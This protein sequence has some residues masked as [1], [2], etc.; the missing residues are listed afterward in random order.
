M[1]YKTFPVSA[2][3]PTYNGVGLL[4]K[5]LPA[6]I[7]CL[8]G[9]SEIIIVDDASTDSSIEW[10]SQKYGL[11]AVK[12]LAA[13]FD[14]WQGKVGELMLKVVKNHRNLRFSAN[15]NRGVELATHDWIFLLNSDV[16]PFSD[17]M[18]QVVTYFDDPTL[19]A[20]GCLEIE[21]DTKVFGGKNK[22]WFERGLFV[23]SRADTYTTG[24]TAWVSGGSGFFNRSK[25]VELKGFDEAYYPAYWEDVDLSYR[26]RKKG[27]K[28]W[29]EA[30]A[31]VHHNHE[32]TN[33]SVFGQRKMEI[34]S[35]TNAQRFV[36]KNGTPWQ[37]LQYLLWLPYHIL[38][39]N[40]RTQGAF[41]ESLKQVWSTT[42]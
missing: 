11:K 17:I 12:P 32:T 6:V 14:L 19:F 24:E 29:F 38:T 42:Q 34:I 41:L 3:I 15:C 39:T 9:G 36:W 27:W 20:I 22:I 28:V 33:V 1:A 8:T 23:H 31:Q 26:A 2:V 5:N 37:K 25:W 16:S 40:R 18:Q 4:Q 35:L 30:K 21:G 7:A 10:L 13:D